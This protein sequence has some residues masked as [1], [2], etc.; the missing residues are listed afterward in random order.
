MCE[1]RQTERNYILGF[2][3]RQ[4]INRANVIVET[5]GSETS[6]LQ[7][8]QQARK[9]FERDR[10][11][12]AV[13]VVCDRDGQDLEPA[14]KLAARPL[15]NA[16]GTRFKIQIIVSDPCFELWLLLHFEYCARPM[17]AGEALRLVRQ[18]VTDYKKSDRRI[19]DVVHLG[20]ERAIAHVEQ[21]KSE[22]RRVNAITPDSDMAILIKALMRLRRVSPSAIA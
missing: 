21:L 16:E 1:G 4:G 3:E 22:L 6:A 5:G 17:S 18:H 20:I 9:R 7:L 2:C 12:D 15:K 11:F 10:D 19:Y 13:F 8:V 14:R